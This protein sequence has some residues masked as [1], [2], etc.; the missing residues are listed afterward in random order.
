MGAER[1]PPAVRAVGRRHA[2]SSY[3]G[4]TRTQKSPAPV[5]F[6]MVAGP[7]SRVL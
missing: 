7:G 3:T 4:A 2:A 5:V 1:P 6:L